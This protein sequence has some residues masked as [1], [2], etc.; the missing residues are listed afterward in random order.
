MEGNNS[1][2][3][4][5]PAAQS[6][7]APVNANNE[8]LELLEGESLDEGSESSSE[9]NSTSNSKVEAKTESK[10]EPSKSE[11]KKA[12]EK[13]DAKQVKG[14]PDKFTIKVDGQVLELSKDE[15][16][17]YAQ[18]GKAGQARMEEAARIKTEAMQ[19]VKMLRDNP[20]AVLADPYV[21]GSEE[22]V[23][24]LAQKILSKKMED[25][26]KSPEAREKERLEKE[27]EELRQKV[28]QDE[29]Q[30][31]AAE[32]ERMVQQQ[33][34]QLEEQITEA[35]ETSGLPKSPFVLK[36][37]ADVMI[38]AAENEKDISPKQ[39]LNIVKREMQKD[40]REYI[41]AL[42]ED[43]L[44]EFISAEKVKK[45]RNRQIAKLKAEQAAAPKPTETKEVASAPV[46]AKK[47][48]KIN[49]RK[50]LRG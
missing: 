31:Q 1:S 18:L 50:F 35:L 39:A 5:A 12:A 40:I 20:E 25:E 19:L 4:A 26:Q 15:M 27:L 11:V 34:A 22:K 42:Q 9:A 32:Y 41:D 49:M 14:D 30:R 8:A 47:N 21:L 37:L 23:I 33:E 10:G 17:K 44:E 29:E 24:E 48:E 46:E 3:P 38:A 28:K 43:A 16:V 36:R 6:T 2:A 7:E 45:L 13:V